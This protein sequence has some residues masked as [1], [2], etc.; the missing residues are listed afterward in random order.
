MK[1]LLLKDFYTLKGYAKQYGIMFILMAGWAVFMKNMSFLVIY[2]VILGGM[3]VLST[4]SMDEA[5]HFDR[6][7]IAAPAGAKGMVR[8]K[9]VLLLL[10]V[11]AGIMTGFLIN[12]VLEIFFGEM[13]AFEWESFLIT[14]LMFVIGYAV[15]LPINFKLGVEKA[16]YAYIGTVLGITP[17]LLGAFKLLEY[18]G[19]SLEETVENSPVPMIAATGICV[20]AL[21]VSYKVS[22]KAV[23]NREW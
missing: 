5:V 15:M 3:L 4:L 2:A 21:V 22:L 19:I 10:T 23:K 12:L 18:Q 9:Y 20:L 16:R 14:A 6:W 11:A 8:E 13:E 7:S 17:L 1:G